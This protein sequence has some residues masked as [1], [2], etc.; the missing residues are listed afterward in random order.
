MLLYIFE[1]AKAN[2]LGYPFLRTGPKVGAL[3]PAI[4]VTRLKFC[5]R[6]QQFSSVLLREIVFQAA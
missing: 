4:V 3:G 1:N 5:L 6:L 2:S